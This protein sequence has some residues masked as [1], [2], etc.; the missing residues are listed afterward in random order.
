MTKLSQYSVTNFTSEDQILEK[1]LENKIV[2]VCRGRM[3]MGQRALGNRSI[4]ADP[5]RLANVEKINN[6]IKKRDF[7]MPFAPI[8]LSEYQDILIENPKNIESPFMTIGFPTK[9]GKTIFPAG[10]HQSD[11][12][13]RAQLLKK[14]ENPAMWNLIF[15]FYEKTGVPALLNTSFN[16]HGEPI[17]RTVQDGLRVFEKSELEVLWLEN[18]IIEKK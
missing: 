9:Q 2:A 14:E 15:K 10:V 8:I 16:L 1:I 18:H 5:R 6:S 7:W 17:V 12:T 3:E 11:G 13:T 4:I